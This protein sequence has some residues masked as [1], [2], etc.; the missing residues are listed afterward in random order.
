M[1]QYYNPVILDEHG[2]VEHWFNCYD[3]SNG[4][5]LMEHSYIGNDFVAAVESLLAQEAPRRVVWAGDYADAEPDSETGGPLIVKSD[6]YTAGEGEANLYVLAELSG[7]DPLRPD[8]PGLGRQVH[9]QWFDKGHEYEQLHRRQKPIITYT[10]DPKIA[11]NADFTPVRVTT[12]SHNWLLNWDK[13]EF[14]SKAKVP[15]ARY[16]YSQK[17]SAIHPLPLLTVEGNGRGGGDFHVPDGSDYLNDRSQARGNFALIGSWARDHISV[18]ASAPVN[19]G[20]TEILFDLVEM[21]VNETPAD[22]RAN[23][24]MAAFYK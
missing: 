14:V 5:K 4:A 17:P 13:K 12:K 8:L 1:G 18:S 23:K 20:F 2:K 10:K 22:K 24:K 6:M 21:G 3:F 16:Y 11:P 19:D 7:K 9:Y 15:R